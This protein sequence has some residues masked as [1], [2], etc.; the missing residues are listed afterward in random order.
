M[1]QQQLEATVV[2]RL[3]LTGAACQAPAVG[4]SL[5]AALLSGT[6]AALSGTGAAWVA[7]S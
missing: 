1:P 3:L 6:G 7:L 5:L 4:G 2:A